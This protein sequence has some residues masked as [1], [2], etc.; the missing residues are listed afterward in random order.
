MKSEADEAKNTAV[1]TK[2]EG[3]SCRGSD[4]MEME[5]L[6]VF[7]VSFWLKLASVAVYPG[8]IAF[9]LIPDIPKALA[10]AWVSVKPAPLLGQQTLT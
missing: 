5:D 4:C 3:T 1:P 2:S 6:D 9:T 8:A 10:G 7:S